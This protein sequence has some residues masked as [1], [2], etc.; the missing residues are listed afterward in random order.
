MTLLVLFKVSKN[1]IGTQASY[2][3]ILV[4]SS[5]PLF[6]LLSGRLIFGENLANLLISCLFLIMSGDDD[7]DKINTMAIKMGCITG[8][9]ML[10]K[11]NFIVLIPLNILLLIIFNFKKGD[12]PIRLLIIVLQFILPLLI[13]EAPW[14][15]YAKISGY[16]FGDAF[17]FYLAGLGRV[18]PNLLMIPFWIFI[19]T[20]FFILSILPFIPGL[21]NGIKAYSKDILNFKFDKPVV[22]VFIGLSSSLILFISFSIYHSLTQYFNYPNPQLISS[23]YYEFLLPIVIILSF[24]RGR[25][26]NIIFIKNIKVA[27]FL[28]LILL[29]SLISYLVIY[30]TSYVPW[31]GNAI[32]THSVSLLFSNN[33]SI[34]LWFFFSILIF[35]NVCKELPYIKKIVWVLFSVI[36]IINSSLILFNLSIYSTSAN[37]ISL[38]SRSIARLNPYITSELIISPKGYSQAVQDR[39]APTDKSLFVKYYEFWTIP[40]ETNIKFVDVGKFSNAFISSEYLSNCKYAF[41]N[42]GSKYYLCSGE[43]QVLKYN[44]SGSDEG[45][46]FSGWSGTERTHRWTDGAKAEIKFS[47]EKIASDINSCTLNL[48]YITAG[49]KQLLVFINNH[50][51]GAINSEGWFPGIKFSSNF[52]SK[53]LKE[54]NSLIFDIKNPLIISKDNPR[55]LGI[56]LINLEI[57][58]K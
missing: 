29:Y 25:I 36:L 5:I 33:Y 11:Y 23:R 14:L 38:L 17:G 58:C 39:E 24:Y 21:V 26:N 40:I 34:L 44:A 1:L 47:I 18:T 2:I 52:S 46:I 31:F 54:N 43:P 56:G 51:I 41:P 50:E 53:F 3:T 37:N 48:K 9:L 42:N 35:I 16:T 8:L 20:S 13:I 19:Y 32:G 27:I 4:I 45:L 6:G 12:N 55:P 49:N 28:I 57:N 30:K 7:R 10:T 15:Y 22:R